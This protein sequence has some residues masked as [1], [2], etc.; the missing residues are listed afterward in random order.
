MQKYLIPGV[1]TGERFTFVCIFFQPPAK[2]IRKR[3][4]K[5]NQ[6]GPQA[7]ISRPYPKYMS[8]EEVNQALE[9]Y[10][11]RGFEKLPRWLQHELKARNLTW[12]PHPPTDLEAWDTVADARVHRITHNELTIKDYQDKYKRGKP[13]TIL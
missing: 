2:S 9:E 6:I 12:R 10:G 13:F 5:C 1:L 8:D 7:N 11:N 4:I 3:H